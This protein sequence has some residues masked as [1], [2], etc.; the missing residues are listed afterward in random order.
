MKF[1]KTIEGNKSQ[2]VNVNY[3]EGGMFGAK[4][5]YVN[6]SEVERDGYFEKHMVSDANTSYK[7]CSAYLNRKNAKKENE[8]SKFVE[9]HLDTIF[10]KH[11]NRDKNGLYDL[12]HNIV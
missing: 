12:L 9:E 3:Y 11:A 6:F 4:G 5:I 10:E 8:V 7:I 2:K 1:Y